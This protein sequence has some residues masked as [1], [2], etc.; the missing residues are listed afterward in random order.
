VAASVVELE[1]GVRAGGSVSE[2]VDAGLLHRECRRIFRFKS[3]LTDPGAHELR[4]HQH[5]RDA[6][7]VARTGQSHVLTTGTGSGKSLAYIVPIVDRV[8]RRT[9]C[10]GDRGVSD[11]R[12][13]ELA[14]ARVGEVPAVRLWGGPGAGVVRLVHRA[15]V[16]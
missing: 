9:G 13:G 10:E 16:P 6:I 5:Q 14:V 4:L 7:E 11:E 15:G 12:V 1:S 2:L 8:L 3:D